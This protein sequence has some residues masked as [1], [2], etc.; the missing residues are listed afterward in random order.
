MS[1]WWGEQKKREDFRAFCGGQG[2]IRTHGTD[3]PY[4]AFPMLHLQPLGHLSNG[5]EL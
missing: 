5:G 2:G 4:T 1:A 3:M